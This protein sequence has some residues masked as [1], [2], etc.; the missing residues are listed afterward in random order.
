MT[1]RENILKVAGLSKLHL[2]EADIIKFKREFQGILNFVH[3]AGHIDPVDDF[4]C[5]ILSLDD[6]ADD[7]IAPSLS[8]E[9]AQLNA[10]RIRGRYFVVPQVVE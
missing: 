9:D 8:I 5:P 1:D 7:I 4:R 3:A 10:K 6:L 2:T